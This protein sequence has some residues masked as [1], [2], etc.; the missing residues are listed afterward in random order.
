MYSDLPLFKTTYDLTLNMY[1]LVRNFTKEFKYTL[2]EQLKKETTE[3]VI[4]IYQAN[5]R[6]DKKIVIE[7]AKE[8]IE[9]IRLLVRLSK[10]LKII[11]LKSFVNINKYI[12]SSSKQISGWEKSINNN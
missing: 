6:R 10:D 5:N 11:S 9:T 1:M 7:Q 2:G 3:L 4:L 8:K 12:Q